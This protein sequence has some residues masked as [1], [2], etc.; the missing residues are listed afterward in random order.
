[1]DELA[2]L[3]PKL[4]RLKLSGMLDTLTE[5]LQ[6]ALTEK[7]SYTQFLDILLTD[8]AERRDFKQLGRRLT[9]SGLAPD[10]TLETFDFS[11]NPRIHAPTLHELATCRFVQRA[12]NVFFVGPSGVGKS[13]AAQALGHIACRKGYAVT[14]ERTSVLLDWIHAGRGDPGII[15]MRGSAGAGPP[16]GGGP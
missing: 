6:Q 15:P 13:H 7:W 11:F 14:Y 3:K 9:K 2:L 8:E 16:C 12:E 1:M 5:R 4:T 10:K